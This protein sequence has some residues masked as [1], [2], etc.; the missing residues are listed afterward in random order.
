MKK[1]FYLFFLISS[2]NCFTQNLVPN[3]SFEQFIYCPTGPSDISGCLSWSSYGLSSDY[4]NPCS[5]S[6]DFT[7]PNNYYGFQY[8]HSGNAYIGICPFHIQWQ[9]YREFVGAQLTTLF[10]IGQ[11]YYISFY[12]NLSGNVFRGITIGINKMGVKFSTIQYSFT[13][14]APINNAAHF[15]TDSI[16]TDT[17]KWTKISSS[18]IADSAYSYIIIGNFF[19]DANTDTLNL[20]TTNNN[21][22]YYYIEDVCVSIDSLYCENW[23]GVKEQNV[24]KE[25]ITIYPN[26]C[27]NELN[28]KYN[29]VPNEQIT[30]SIINIFGKVVM[31]A[32]TQ[33]SEYT[34]NTG[35]L[36]KGLYL[37]KVETGGIIL[38]QRVVKE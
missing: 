30:I 8:S 18:F 33:E 13:N 2:L 7:T 4:F 12:V 28:V 38:Q 25:E 35:K 31:Q 9:N 5:T 22:A 6:S 27:K 37:V 32:K 26:P 19:D 23:L 34:F 3:P 21:Y 1:I 14:S 24:N 16:I 29:N 11:K 10:I 36:A 17:A 15:Y 20:A